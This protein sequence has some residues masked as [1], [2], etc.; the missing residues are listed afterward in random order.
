[1]SQHLEGLKL[2]DSILIRGPSG[3]IVYEAPGIF[4]VRKNKTSPS[5]KVKATKIG[6]IAGGTGLTPMYQLIHEV[7]KNPRDSSKLWLLLANQSE[8]D[9]LLRNELETLQKENPDRFSLWFTVDRSS[10]GWK[11][12]VGFINADMIQARLP[13]PAE[14]T[15]I[16]LCGPPPMI[17]FACNPNLDK[18]GHHLTNRLTF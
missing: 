8:D 13:S 5:T 3:N 12:D 9:I 18:I 11:Y 1:M 2:G 15:V 4:A 16:L 14:D 17:N 10:P 6:M 7:L